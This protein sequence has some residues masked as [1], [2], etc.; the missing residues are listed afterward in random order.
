M[1]S[2]IKNIHLSYNSYNYRKIHFFLYNLVFIF[3]SIQ[4]KLKI[5]HIKK[6]N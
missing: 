4:I 6:I 2:I 3:I 5:Y 1:Y